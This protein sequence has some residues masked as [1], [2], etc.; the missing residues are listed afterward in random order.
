M[1]IVYCL[2]NPILEG[3]CKVGY[4]KNLERRIKDLSS[5]GIPENYKLEF[6]INYSINYEKQI[7]NDIVKLGIEKKKEFFKCSPMDIKTIFEKYG[8]IKYSLPEVK[9]LENNKEV[10]KTNLIKKQ[11]IKCNINCKCPFCDYKSQKSNVITHLQKQKKC[12]SDKTL[13]EYAEA[14]HSL[15]TSVQ[16]SKRETCEYCQSK[17]SINSINFHKEECKFNPINISS[18]NEIEKTNDNLEINI[19]I[20][21]EKLD[22]DFIIKKLNEIISHLKKIKK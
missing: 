1:Y 20:L 14:V 5:A 19:P 22:L 21:E 13:Q 10:V 11:Q 8:E 4:T 17:Y 3:L 16:T 18:I 6:Y 15:L 12:N 2:T 9:K 7:Q